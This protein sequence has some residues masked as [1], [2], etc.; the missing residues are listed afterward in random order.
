MFPSPY[1]DVEIPE[2]SIYDHLFGS[3]L[4]EDL[5]RVAFIDPDSGAPTSYGQLRDDVDALAGALAVMGP[6]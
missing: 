6:A 4:E 1:P 2:V 3:L 5:K